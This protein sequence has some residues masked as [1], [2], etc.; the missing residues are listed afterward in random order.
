M[1]E[2]PLILF[3]VLS[4]AAVGLVLISMLLMYVLSSA[5][6]VALLPA[7]KSAGLIAFPVALLALVA[8]VFHLGQPFGGMRALGNLGSSWLSREILLM[9]LFVAGV[10]I[11]SYLWLARAEAL[12]A[13][14]TVGTATALLGLGVI[15]ATGMVYQLPTRPEW[16]H[17]SNLM[18]GFI[19][20]L[21]LG[22]LVLSL[23]AIRLPNISPLCRKAL[24]GVVLLA[25]V[26]LVLG[27]ISYG[28][29]LLTVSAPTATLLFG[30]PWFWARLLLGIGLPV[31]VAA[32]MLRESQ[33]SVALLSLTLLAALGGELVGR[34]LFYSS[35]LNQLPYF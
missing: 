15:Y 30:S 34:T 13:I 16:H 11:Y 27:L 20:A 9:A 26:L 33:P 7:L 28:P 24:G 17:W 6:R 5:Q 22:G 25:A 4:Q 18:A 29:Y 23:L 3:T 2:L 35:V 19:T 12:A 31:F 8:S 1:R 32:Q 10:A 14:R 21:L